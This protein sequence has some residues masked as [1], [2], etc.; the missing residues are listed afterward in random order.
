[1]RLPS[2]FT[3]A[4]LVFG[5][6]GCGGESA[7][8]AVP[9]TAASVA[10]PEPEARDQLAG[11]AALALDRRYAALYTFDVGD[12]SPRDVVASVADDGTWRVDIPLGALGGTAGVTIIKVAAGVY[13]C[14]LTTSTQPVSPTCIR[15][16]ER[17]DKV[18]RRYDP[19]VQ[20]LFRQWLTVFTDRKAPLAV[21]AVRPLAGAQGG[22]CYAVDSVSAALDP[23]V[24]VGI[25]CYSA[26][27]LLTAARVEYG[28]LKLVRQV[29]GPPTLQLPG[30]E[31]AGEPMGM[32]SPPPV[33]QPSGLTP[34]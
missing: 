27:G 12:G 3:V 23:P 32:S 26:D 9:E 2:A 7:P 6:A 18:P 25:Y 24:D 29:A 1:M 28:V 30:P 17:G 5:L 21:S 8:E 20:R 10:D 31:V 11:L 15:V 22:T 13:Q 16:A 14:G 19:K 34:S 4:V 33:V